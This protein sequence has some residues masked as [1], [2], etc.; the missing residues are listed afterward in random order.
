M[1]R[2]AAMLPSAVAGAGSANSG[3]FG[4]G[5]PVVMAL[6]ITGDAAS[7]A[8]SSSRPAFSCAVQGLGLGLGLALGLGLGLG[9]GLR[10]G[11]HGTGGI[12]WP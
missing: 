2:G 11:L 3:C 8:L 4:S 5:L 12:I 1:A 6:S 7:S 10:L 9:L